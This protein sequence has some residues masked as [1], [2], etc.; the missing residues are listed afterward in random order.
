[1]AGTVHIPVLFS[2]VLDVLALDKGKTLLDGTLGGGGHS[3]GLLERGAARV[4]A[5]DWDAAALARCSFLTETYGSRVSLH[6]AGYDRLAAVLAEAGLLTVDG[7]LLDLGFS[8]DQLDDA[9]RGLSYHADGPL[10]MRLDSRT[11]TTAAHILNTFREEQLADI[12]YLYG[13]EPR[14]RVLARAAVQARKD[15]PFA[16]TGDLLR[17]VE[18]VYPPHY[19]LKRAHPAARIFQALRIAVNDELRVLEAALPQAAAALAPGG[20]LA[21]ITFQPLEDRLVK[22]FYKR[23]AEPELDS[24]GRQVRG[25]AFKVWKKIVPGPAELDAN[26]RAR[27]ACLRVLEKLDGDGREP[28]AATPLRK[29][30]KR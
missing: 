8:S 13:E 16:L 27:S 12:F 2:E 6:H 10:D 5:L 20:R 25:G 21:I 23:C 15:R 7:I 14:A 19:G 4:L 30:K 29:G 26:P 28:I 3:A 17:L 18:S 9:A 22:A 24:V 1:M 11:Q